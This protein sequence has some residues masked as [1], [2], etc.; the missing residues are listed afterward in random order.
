M[1][2]IRLGRRF[3]HFSR[4]SV[5]VSRQISSA[6]EPFSI[7]DE[8]STALKDRRPVVALESTIYTHGQEIQYDISEMGG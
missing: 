4:M 2:F 8:V 6:K 3:L 7:S 5:N 1:A